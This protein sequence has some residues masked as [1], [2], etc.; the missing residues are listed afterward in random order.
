MQVK[1][2]KMLFIYP[3][4]V[5]GIRGWEGVYIYIEKKKKKKKKGRKKAP[6][7]HVFGVRPFEGTINS[8][9]LSSK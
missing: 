1:E 7:T 5:G 9:S 3:G 6:R 2:N 4:L 8:I